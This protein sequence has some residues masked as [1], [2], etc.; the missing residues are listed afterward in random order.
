MED[1]KVRVAITVSK[2]FWYKVKL[3]A[4]SA[5]MNLG[6]FVESKLMF[7]M[8]CDEA[9]ESPKPEFCEY[10]G[11]AHWGACTS[12]DLKK[13][14]EE[15]RIDHRE[16][17]KH[18][19]SSAEDLTDPEIEAANERLLKKRKEAKKRPKAT[20]KESVKTPKGEVLV[21]E[22]CSN[23]MGTLGSQINPQPKAKWK[24]A[25]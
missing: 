17:Q 20:V 13:A 7:A 23:F 14:A 8:Q 25:K 2:S 22:A 16:I 3:S 1:T 10:C 6:E 11:K 24:G 21:N 9:N 19:Q 4:F 18:L 5:E 12:D 15:P